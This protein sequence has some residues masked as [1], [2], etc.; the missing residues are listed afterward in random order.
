MMRLSVIVPVYNV[1]KFLPRCLDSLL[2]QGMEQSE[3]E[4]ICVNDGSPDKCA[5]ILAEYERRCP[6]IFKIITQENQGLGGAR[7]TGT[8]QAQGEYVTY[9]DSDD[10]LIDGAYS[11]LLDHFC[12]DKPDVLC[13]DKVQIYT[14]G[15]ILHDPDA[16]PD[17]EILFEGDGANAYNRWPLPNVWSKFY[18]RSFIEQHQV[19]SQIVACQDELFN[20]DV[21]CH[22]PH[23]RIVTCRVVRYELGNENSIQ[24]TTDK[25]KVLRYAEDMFFNID[26]I[27]AYLDRGETE[28]TPAAMRD[29]NNF[30]NVYHHKLSLAFIPYGKWLSFRRKMRNLPP[31]KPVVEG[32]SKNAHRLA[33]CKKLAGKS[34]LF[35]MLFTF[36]R[37]VVF[38]QFLRPLLLRESK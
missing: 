14:N 3:W 1:E 35:Y 2:R 16:K 37:K 17:G 20:F 19:V 31:Y 27:R 38:Y 23:T 25:K 28:M 12:Q 8:A 32:D 36:L 11:Y 33:A 4:I 26:Y 24:R 18:K 13:Y 6:N 22:H 21:F 29:I 34:Y 9:L 5:D 15:L 30:L 7:N 10:Y